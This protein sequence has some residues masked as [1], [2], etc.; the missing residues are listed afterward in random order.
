MSRTSDVALDSSRSTFVGSFGFPDCILDG[1]RTSGFVHPSP[2]QREA[3]PK[4]KM[5]MDLIV[6]VRLKTG[7]VLTDFKN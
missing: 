1:L 4:A 2:V 3:I 6:Q 7:M 5:G